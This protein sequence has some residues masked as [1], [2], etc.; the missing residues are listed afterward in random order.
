[1]VDGLNPYDGGG[2]GAPPGAAYGDTSYSFQVMQQQMWQTMQMQQIQPTLPGFMYYHPRAYDYRQQQFG[3]VAPAGTWMPPQS[4][5]PRLPDLGLSG[6]LNAIYQMVG[7][8]LLSSLGVTAS[9]LGRRPDFIEDSRSVGWMRDVSAVANS[10]Q[11]RA[12]METKF[13]NEQRPMFAKYFQREIDEANGRHDSAAV[14]ALND[15]IDATTRAAAKDTA[16]LL[17]SGNSISSFTLQSMLA[18]IPGLGDELGAGM[19]LARGIMPAVKMSMSGSVGANIFGENGDI[20]A[21]GKALTQALY[22]AAMPNGVLNTAFT[23]GFTLSDITSIVHQEAIRGGLSAGRA[24]DDT[25]G[26]ANRVTE[27]VRRAAETMA[28]FQKIFNVEIPK[29]YDIVEKMLGAAT[30]SVSRDRLRGIALNIQGVARETG[31]SATDVAGFFGQY[32][33][34]GHRLGLTPGAS[35][36]LAAAGMYVGQSSLIAQNGSE[37]AGGLSGNQ[38]RDAAVSSMMSRGG[39]RLTKAQ[40][41]LMQL[42]ADRF[43]VNL[44]GKSGDFAAKILEDKLGGTGKNISLLTGLLRN[45]ETAME[46]L[47]VNAEQIRAQAIS[48][49]LSSSPFSVAAAIEH[50]A[51]NPELYVSGLVT[52]DT[53]GQQL[54]GNVNILSRMRRGQH[55][56]HTIDFFRKGMLR[57]TGFAGAEELQAFAAEYARTEMKISDP[58]NAAVVGRELVTGV[59]QALQGDSTFGGFAAQPVQLFNTYGKSAALEAAKRSRNQ[60]VLG[61]LGMA[62]TKVGGGATNWVQN[63]YHM[64]F[65]KEKA[66]IN[67]IFGDF[68]G[69]R[70]NKLTEEQKSTLLGNFEAVRQKL[71]GMSEANYATPEAREAAIR[72]TILGS[73]G[74]KELMESQVGG[75]SVAE[76]MSQGNQ[77]FSRMSGTGTDRWADL[78]IGGVAA[79]RMLRSDGK[80]SM[81]SPEQ[82]RDFLKKVRQ[83]PGASNQDITDILVKDFGMEAGDAAK[84]TGHM[85]TVLGLSGKQKISDAV[86]NV[87]DAKDIDD[88][89]VLSI[90]SALGDA[91]AAEDLK[92]EQDKRRQEQE[93]KTKITGELQIT[94]TTPTTGT[95]KLNGTTTEEHKELFSGK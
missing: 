57:E 35:A 54:T 61:A 91:K 65:G 51:T 87:H 11:M 76:V 7:P 12:N 25:K 30:T 55:G 93:P 9:T 64:L 38:L 78:M 52:P 24:S 36:D 15:K 33:D 70:F 3:A 88:L 4:L 45:D 44:A 28:E 60:D 84:L 40:S 16:S 90:N 80:T 73:G 66:T 2:W 27:N 39:S 75:I 23:S 72:D 79:K 34:Y 92:K 19:V 63:A 18:S 67:A 14:K 17:T 37:L 47:R 77:W 53:L 8:L 82:Y 49:G 20:T 85:Q 48:V 89:T 83:N 26:V 56:A 43:G 50:G 58:A 81:L 69:G 42:I 29:L 10:P 32:I 31:I 94:L 5:G 22:T 62:M 1:M 95:G 6:P 21:R 68:M 46:V 71:Q 74:V 13:F 41:G 59:A 86:A